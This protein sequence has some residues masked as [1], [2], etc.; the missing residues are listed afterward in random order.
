LQKARIGARKEI[1]VVEAPASFLENSGRAKEFE[2]RGDGS[3][4]V[5]AVSRISGEKGI[6]NIISTYENFFRL[7]QNTPEKKLARPVKFI[8]SRRSFK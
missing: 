8:S 1:S 5:L 3:L 6:E 4:V 7:M 2:E